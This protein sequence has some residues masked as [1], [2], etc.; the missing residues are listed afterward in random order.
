MSI[1]VNILSS[2]KREVHEVIH[3][4]LYLT[5]LLVMPVLMILFFV[6][7][8]YRGTI[9]SLP[10]AVV[11][12]SDSVMSRRVI[13]MINAT[14]GVDVAYEVLS[15]DEAESLMLSGRVSAVLYIDD[16]FEADIYHGVPTSVECYISGASVSAAGVVESDV[17][18]AVRT[19]SAGVALNRLQAS[20]LSYHQAL[21]DIMPVNFHTYTLS[22]PY[23]NYGYYL[24][25][26]FMFMGIVIFTVLM[27]IYAVGRELHYATAPEWLSSASGMVG[28]ALIG[29]LLPIAIVMA[30]FMQLVFFVLFVVMGMDCRGSYMMLTLGSLL[31]ITA[32]QSVAVFIV[33]LTSNLRLSLS[34]GGGYAVMAFTFS[35]ITFPTMS[36]YGFAR[37]FAHLFPLSYF[38]DLFIDQATRGVGA[39]RSIWELVALAI[40]LLLVPI[41]WRSFKR[42]VSDKTYF[43]KD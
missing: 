28:A 11:D 39:V 42:V 16:D 29:K 23:L 33:A 4:R 6:V 43:K 41:I 30:I 24:A 27:T 37:A 13:T 3:D 7:M 21:L 35:G 2:F 22:N 5:S 10:I 25:P 8:F 40:F 32:Y 19:F 9:V 20:G 17:Q 18:Q 26:V 31:L 38:S 1:I 34:L 15:M 12:R 14:R 36:M